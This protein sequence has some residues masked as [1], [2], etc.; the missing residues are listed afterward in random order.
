MGNAPFFK[1]AGS[2]AVGFEMRGVDLQLFR[3]PV[4]G[5]KPRE[6]LVEHAHAAPAYKAVI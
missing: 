4:I 6:Y 1:Q 2:G 3:H 5:G